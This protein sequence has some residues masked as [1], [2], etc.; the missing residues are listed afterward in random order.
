[1][2]AEKYSLNAFLYN[3]K[4]QNTENE[5]KFQFKLN[6]MCIHE[7][8]SFQGNVK[9]ADGNNR[10]VGRVEFFE[11][12]QW[13]NV[14]GQSWDM[15]DATVVCRQLNCGRVHTIT[16]MAEYGHGLG[17][18]WIDRIECSGLEFTLP[19]CPQRPYRDTVCNT[20]SVAGVVCTGKRKQK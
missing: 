20:T 10:C 16:S 1:M 14:C 15:N 3:T 6:C 4:T 17:Q 5:F 11:K 7:C 13:G 18:V 19:E 2:T 12:G 8:L 9:L